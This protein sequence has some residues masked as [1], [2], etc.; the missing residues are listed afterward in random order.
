MDK[1]KV[2][3]DLLKNS[4]KGKELLAYSINDN[5]IIFSA[6]NGIVAYNLKL[7]DFYLNIDKVFRKRPETTL[8]KE[9]INTPEKDLLININEFKKDNNTLLRCYELNNKVIYFNDKILKTKKEDISIY[10]IKN[11]DY[12]YK[13]KNKYDETLG[14]ICEYRIKD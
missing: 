4:V 11:S 9:I 6:F 2:Q 8:F 7:S 3:S 10:S 12:I 14:I 13:V 1:I 5:Y